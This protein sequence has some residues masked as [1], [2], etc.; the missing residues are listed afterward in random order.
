MRKCE[1]LAGYACKLAKKKGDFL[2]EAE[3]YQ[4]LER[5]FEDNLQTCPHGRP[6]YWMIEVSEIEKRLKRKL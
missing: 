3:V 1:V 4:L 6:L 5:F 2:H